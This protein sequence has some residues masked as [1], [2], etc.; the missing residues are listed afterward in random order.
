MTVYVPVSRDAAREL[1]SSG[2]AP[3]LVGYAD[4]PALRHW[5][6]EGA[7]DDDEINYLTLNHAGVASLTLADDAPTRLVLALDLALIGTDEIGAVP[8]S[9]VTW[10]RV[11]SLFADD[12]AAADAVLKARAAVRGLALAAALNEPAVTELEAAHDLL[13]FAPEEL[14]AIIA[15]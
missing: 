12:P 8:V 5:L 9:G 10:T 6:G 2:A 14:D 11:R 15:R 7:L 4:G 13:W 1:R 3:A